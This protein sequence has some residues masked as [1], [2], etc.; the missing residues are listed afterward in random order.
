MGL[1]PVVDFLKELSKNNNKEWF[2]EHRTAYQGHRVEFLGLVQVLIDGIAMFDPSLTGVDPKKCVFR[3]NRDIRF[4]KDK[5][6]YKTNFGALM[7]DQGKKSEGT[8]FYV[9]LAPGHNFVGGGMYKPLPDMLAKIRQ[10]ID[11]NPK[12]LMAVIDTEN[13]KSTFGKIQGEQLKT[14]PKG[15]PKDHPFIDLLRYK[16]FYVLKEFSDEEVA[17]QGFVEEALV[18]CQKAAKFNEFLRNAI[19]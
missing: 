18:V 2:D 13:F 7:G 16:S 11:Y 4:S 3:I 19:N 5:T 14:A 9:H 6:P 8:G 1:K 15:Y 17:A 12:D 10:E